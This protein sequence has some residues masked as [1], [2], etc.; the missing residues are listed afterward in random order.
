MVRYGVVQLSLGECAVYENV[1]S[2]HHL[3]EMPCAE[4]QIIRLI[5]SQIEEIVIYLFSS[6]TRQATGLPSTALV[7]SVTG[8]AVVQS[9]VA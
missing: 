2:P 1:S 7:G 6:R 4:D 9:A 3:D 5:R 8:I